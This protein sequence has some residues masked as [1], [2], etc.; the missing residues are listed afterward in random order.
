ML[1]NLW[2]LFLI[3]IGGLFAILMLYV[4]LKTFRIAWKNRIPYRKKHH[5]LKFRFK[6]FLYHVRETR[7]VNF[8]EFLKW[9]I[10]DIFRGVDRFKL[11]GIWCFCGYYGQGK[12]L[13]AVNFAFKLQKR[14]PHKNIKIY[15][16]FNVKGQ[17]GKITE[18]QSLLNLPRNTIVL[19]DEIQ[20]TFSSQKYNAFPIELLWKLTQCRKHGL[21]IFCTSP[22]FSRMSIQ[23]R[24][25]AD[26]V[27]DCKNWFKLDRWFS[28]DFYK[29]REYEMK[30]NITGMTKG[31]KQRKLRSFKYTLVAQ[32]SNYKRYNTTEQIDRW[33]IEEKDKNE[34][35]KIK[36]N[37]Y[38]SLR[39]DLLKEIEYRLKKIDL[40][41]VG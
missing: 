25:S 28:Y 6:N 12:S 35:V 18:W 14:Y 11:F 32:D 9:V 27:I 19:F 7:Y 37:D 17:D 4:A 24:E 41:K 34:K 29:V 10:V 3:I 38:Q 20:S 22:V 1:T 23:L 21:A 30:E 36:K 13:G 5:K 40:K 26:Y 33:D 8:V 15:S 31:V 39:N 16:N 2:Y